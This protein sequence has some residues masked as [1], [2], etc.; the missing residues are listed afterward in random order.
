MAVQNATTISKKIWYD[1]RRDW[2]RQL[3]VSRLFVVPQL[4]TGATVHAAT[5]IATG[6][7]RT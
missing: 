6:S 7:D 3:D 2:Q 1:R 5:V 4:Q